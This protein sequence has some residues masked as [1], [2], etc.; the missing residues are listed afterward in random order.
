MILIWD[1]IDWGIFKLWVT[2]PQNY[3]HQ[4]FILRGSMHELMGYMEWAPPACLPA[5][6]TW[7]FTLVNG[8]YFFHVL[9]YVW[10]N[11]RIPNTYLPRSIE[12]FAESALNPPPPLPPIF[13]Q[14]TFSAWKQQS[15][16]KSSFYGIC[17]QICQVKCVLVFHL[18]LFFFKTQ[19]SH[20]RCCEERKM[21]AAAD[22]LAACEE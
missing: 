3:K 4:A 12:C 11:L 16:L 18:P 8:N 7:V 13:T 22:A 6:L 21:A 20:S 5:S 14:G 15:T 10:H 2:F 19:P 1:E 9:K 17:Y